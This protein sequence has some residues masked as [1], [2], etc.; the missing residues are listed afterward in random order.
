M[1]GPAMRCPAMRCRVAMVSACAGAALVLPATPVVPAVAHTDLLASVPAPDTRASE[2]VRTVSLEFR[3]VLVPELSRIAVVGPD[4]LDLVDGP[5]HVLGARATVRVDATAPG[6]YVVAYRTVAADGHPVAGRYRFRVARSAAAT[7]GSAR[8][9]D[10]A[11][12]RGLPDGSSTST[13]AAPVGPGGSLPVLAGAFVLLVVL[14]RWRH[15][16]LTG[17]LP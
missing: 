12:A 17:A 15:A 4:G 6:S 14:A 3:S 16:R 1:G 2:G 7:S 11:E 9:T 13:G 8:G 10:A 5:A